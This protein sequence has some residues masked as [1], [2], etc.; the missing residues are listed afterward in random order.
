MAKVHGQCACLSG[1]HVPRFIVQS[2]VPADCFLS[3]E[4][5]KLLLFF[6][7][8]GSFTQNQIS[9]FLRCKVSLYSPPVGRGLGE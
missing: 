3:H 5:L 6:E 9:G 4:T 7:D 1:T 8:F 2:V